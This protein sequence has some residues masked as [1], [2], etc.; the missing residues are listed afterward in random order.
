MPIPEKTL[1]LSCGC[2]VTVAYMVMYAEPN[3]V[4][5]EV[6]GMI[7]CRR[8][9]GR[10]YQRGEAPHSGGETSRAAALRQ[11]GHL[12]R[13]ERAVLKALLQGPA[14]AELI[15]ERSGL[16]RLTAGA[17][18]TVL[19]RCEVPLVR[20]TGERATLASGNP[21]IVWALTYAGRDA[22]ACEVMP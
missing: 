1:T 4:R 9:R 7:Y 21:G 15:A 16:L 22:L 3:S 19:S 6:V 14:H 10:V 12:Q 5:M 17:R 11:S 8:H 20:D 2:A 13:K 18:L